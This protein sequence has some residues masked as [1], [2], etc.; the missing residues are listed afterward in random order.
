MSK[1]NE[2]AEETDEKVPETEEGTENISPVFSP[3]FKNALKPICIYCGKAL[4]GEA[5]YGCFK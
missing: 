3:F 1:R 5:C 4:N 2:D